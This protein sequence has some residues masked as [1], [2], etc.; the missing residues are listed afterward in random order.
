MLSFLELGLSIEA[1]ALYLSAAPQL[2]IDTAQ[3]G[4]EPLLVV[5]KRFAHTSCL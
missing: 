3:C 1:C 2:R 4:G 5:E